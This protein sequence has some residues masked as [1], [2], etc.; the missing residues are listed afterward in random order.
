MLDLP[1]GNLDT[2]IAAHARSLGAVIIT[3]DI[4][5]FKKVPGLMVEIGSRMQIRELTVIDKTNLKL[6]RIH[7]RI[8]LSVTTSKELIMAARSI[9]SLTMSFGLVPE[10]HEFFVHR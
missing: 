7:R 1:I 3:D 2:M 6:S 5:H 8:K 10:R 9:A 4:R